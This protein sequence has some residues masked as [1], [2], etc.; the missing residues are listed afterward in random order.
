MSLRSIL[1]SML[2]I[3]EN[4]RYFNIGGLSVTRKEVMEELQVIQK[5]NNSL[6]QHSKGQSEEFVPITDKPY[7]F[8]PSLPKLL[9][10]YLPQFHAIP[11]NDKNFGKGF[12][13]WSNVARSV[14]LF[15]G[16]HQ[17]QI[18]YDVGFYDLSHVD[19]MYR[20]VEL[21]K[22]Y[23]I[24]GF[25]FYY[26][27]F[28]GQPILE[29][30]LHNWLNHKDLDMDYCFFWAN[31]SWTNTWWGGQ[32]E[33]LIEQK[34]LPGEERSFVKDLLP[35]FEDSRYIKIN[36][37]PLLIVY[38]PWLLSRERFI[39]YFDGVRQGVKKAGF[40]DL[41]LVNVENFSNSVEQWGFDAAVEFFPMGI[42]NKSKTFVNRK[43]LAD[44][45]LQTWSLEPFLK[46]KDYL[47]PSNHKVFKSI[48]ATWDNSARTAFKKAFRY[49]GITPETF[50]VWLNDIIKYTKENNSDQEQ[51]IF[52]NA[53]NE[54]AEGAHLE[55]DVRYGYKWL[56]VIKNAMENYK[57]E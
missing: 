36:N 37:R 12:T 20:Q 48:F 50:T 22:M 2:G 42:E 28:S 43:V 19:V 44:S 9:A 27:W 29:K 55:P 38:K 57:D 21:A 51:Y 49:E 34:Y 17:P 39:E 30:P 52:I 26:Y 40:D 33:L 4:H 3:N 23:G 1:K 18:P 25:C 41:Y 54:W 8:N 5:T 31:E 14:P 35:F 11:L 46:N 15:E 10:Y 47:Y 32:N 13:E 53:W 16:H 45:K 56:Q 6:L 7:V 24:S